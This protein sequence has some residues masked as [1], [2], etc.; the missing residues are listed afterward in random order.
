[1][2]LLY[3]KWHDLC[4]ERSIVGYFLPLIISFKIQVPGYWSWKVITLLHWGLVTGHLNIASLCAPEIYRYGHAL[5]LHLSP[6]S[7]FCTTSFPKRSLSF[8]DMLSYPASPSSRISAHQNFHFLFDGPLVDN[9]SHLCSLCIQ[10]FSFPL[11]HVL[12]AM[13][14][15]VTLDLLLDL[16]DTSGLCTCRYLKSTKMWSLPY[17]FSSPKQTEKNPSTIKIYIE[18]TGLGINGSLFSIC[19]VLLPE[20]LLT[21]QKFIFFFFLIRQAKLSFFSFFFCLN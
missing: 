1:M 6:R 20:L 10:V 18:I 11:A 21:L 4:V 13:G 17:S 5:Y 2:F 14:Q 3:P 9:I 12:F 7:L 15:S 16:R 8:H 19:S